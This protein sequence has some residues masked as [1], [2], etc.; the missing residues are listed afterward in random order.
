MGAVLL[1]ED[2]GLITPPCTALPSPAS[3]QHSPYVRQH[4]RTE[5][6]GSGH[7]PEEVYAVLC[8]LC[9]VSLVTDQVGRVLEVG[10]GGRSGDR[11]AYSS[12]IM[13]LAAARRQAANAAAAALYDTSKLG[14]SADS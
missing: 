10:G 9:Q 2:R 7:Q 3:P 12:K 1:D 14:T 11:F 6:M 5:S 13:K 8:G 4:L